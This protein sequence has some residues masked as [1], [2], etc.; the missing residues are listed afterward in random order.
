[1]RETRLGFAVLVGLAAIAACSGA[2][3]NEFRALETS[4]VAVV[5]GSTSCSAP[6]SFCCESDVLPDGARAAG[7]ADTCVSALSSCTEATAITQC[8]SGLN[9]SGG[10]VCCRTVSGGTTSQLCELTC[11]PG[12]TQLCWSASDCVAG[13]QCVMGSADVVPAPTDAGGDGGAAAPPTG[14]C[15]AAQDAAGGDHG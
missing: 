7:L 10:Q 8:D 3:P 1:M 14:V 5:C 12:E 4:A 13:D 11:A 6:T 15:A 9:C 2:N